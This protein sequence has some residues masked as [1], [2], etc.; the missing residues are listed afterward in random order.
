MPRRGVVVEQP[1]AAGAQRRA[2]AASTSVDRVRDLLHAGA[3]A[4]EELRDRR[5]R[6]SAARAAGRSR[7]RPSADG[8]HRLP[9]A[10]LLVG[11]LVHA[12]HAERRARRR[13]SP[14]PGRRTAMPTWS[15]R[16][17]PMPV[18]SPH[19]LRRGGTRVMS[20]SL[21]A[22]RYSAS[23]QA[24]LGG[25][26]ASVIVSG[27]RTPM[28]RLLG[29]LKDFSGDRARR[30]RDRGRAGAGRRRRRTRSQ[31][32]IMGQVLQA[33]AGQIPARQAAVEA[34]I[35]MSV[36]ALT[37][38]QGLPVRAGRDRAGRPA[39]PRRRVR[40]RRGR[41]HGVDDQR[42]APAARL[43]ARLQVRRRRR[44]VDHLAHDGLHD[45]FD[46]R[47]DGRVDRAAQRQARHHPRASR[48]RSPRARTSAPPPPRRT[49][50]FAEEIV[51]GR[52]PAAPG[53]PDRGRARTRASARTPPSSRW[54]SC[55]RRSPPDG[56]ITAGTVVADLRRR[57]RGRRDE[58]GQGRGARG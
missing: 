35:P 46:R 34:G 9:Y 19:A 14:R 4:V 25:P 33:G 52:D 17:S 40:H 20:A 47:A 36:P 54:P 1:H 26:M 22:R 24:R 12:A 41:R 57:L 32:V 5:L 55:A 13:R 10:L 21:T 6:A 51:A 42:P 30:G 56:T 2:T 39:H 53:R 15:M 18:T 28:G 16:S 7:R 48:T 8:E 27:A 38:Q 23:G 45:A 58:Q 43:A 11:L 29:T 50:L 31:Y 37:D 44:C 49:A 3:V